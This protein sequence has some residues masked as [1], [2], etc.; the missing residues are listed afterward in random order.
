MI[1]VLASLAA[2]ALLMAGCRSQPPA[3]AVDRS[4]SSAARAAAPSLGGPGYYTVRK[5]DSISSISK[6]FG[7]SPDSILS[8]NGIKNAKSLR[9]G[10]E[11]KIP[12]MDGLLHVVAKGESLGSIGK[13]YKVELTL[14]AD[15]IAETIKSHT[16]F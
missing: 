3:P 6:Q 15:E 5:G 1:R 12:S 8:M 2:I 7:R 14:L 13:R 9:A 11:L 10:T 4:T 16:I